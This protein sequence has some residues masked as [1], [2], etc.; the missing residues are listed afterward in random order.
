MKRIFD[1]A[2][3]LISAAFV[4]LFG[5]L[6]LISPQKSFSESENRALAK[7]PKIE[8]KS[9]VNGDFFE[10]L[11]DFF[12]DQFPLRPLFVSV[13][14]ATELS[15]GRGEN[16]GVVFA[17]DGYLI[18][19]PSYGS[20]SLYEK[21]LAALNKFREE[22][23]AAGDRVSVFFAPR[24]ADVLTSKLGELYPK[25]NL[26]SV[27]GMAKKRLPDLITAT[28][29]L[30]MA[31]ERDEYVWFRTDHHWTSLGAYRA[32]LALAEPLGF[33][34]L[35]LEH[36]DFERVSES[37]LGTV[38]SK[39]GAYS[40]SPD[41]IDIPHSGAELTVT[42][43]EKNKEIHSLYDMQ[44]LSTKDKYAVFLGGNF[45]HIS[46]KG[47]SPRPRLVLIKD[48]FANALIPYLA[49]HFDLE[50]YD[51]RYFKGSISKELDGYGESNILI[52]YGIDTAI[53][54]G[55]LSYLVR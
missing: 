18:T 45:S 19:S 22:R 12:C 34:P 23:R 21:N 14:T 54:D 4:T 25:E 2:L 35:P 46:I 24:G 3:V 41:Q 26:S 37:F 9:L 32:Y 47:D 52:L 6:V 20:L 5:A 16:N 51:L 30:R 49:E 11:S 31:A 15:L 55:S 53:T 43:H 10:A 40:V 29:E 42:Y 44:K 36:W 28:E 13:R 33:T 39:S 1:A 38:Y 48:S 8:A 27:W 17:E 7:A 50:I